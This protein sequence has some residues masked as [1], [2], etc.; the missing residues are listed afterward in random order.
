SYRI[1]RRLVARHPGLIFNTVLE[2]V[3]CRERMDVL[4]EKARPEVV[5]HSAAYKHVP[6]VEDNPVAAVWNNVFGTK[7]VADSAI[8]H[9]VRHFV[10]ISTDK[11]VNPTN[12][13][14]TTKRLGELYCQALKQTGSTRFVIVRF[15][16]V[17]ASGAPSCLF[18][19]NRSQAGGP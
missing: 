11:T 13:M 19:K 7:V 6:L 16:N 12:V 5:L 10:F 9:G 17:L 4:F 14:G 1:D 2:D 3:T 8:A 18:L 15:G